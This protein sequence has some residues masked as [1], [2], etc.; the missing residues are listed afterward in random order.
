MGITFSSLDYLLANCVQTDGMEIFELLIVIKLACK[1]LQRLFFFSNVAFRFEMK[2]P[3]FPCQG[4]MLVCFIYRH[5]I[6]SLAS[7]NF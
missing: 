2:H 6:H 1:L 5:L 4:G 3:V 7:C